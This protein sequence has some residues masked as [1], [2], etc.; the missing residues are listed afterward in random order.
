MPMNSSSSARCCPVSADHFIKSARCC[1]DK[2]TGSSPLVKN[3]AMV[4]PQAFVMASSVGMEGALH[5]RNRFATV[6]SE[7]PARLASSYPD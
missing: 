4:T 6:V 2:T 3:C 5:L 7:S 1:G